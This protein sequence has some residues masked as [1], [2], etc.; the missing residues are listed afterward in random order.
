MRQT[1]ESCFDTKVC[2]ARRR[3]GILARGERIL[4]KSHCLSERKAGLT[5]YDKAQIILSLRQ[6]YSLTLLLKLT[7]L[8]KSTYYRLSKVRQ[9]KYSELKFR[10]VAVFEENKGR[11]GYRR[12]TAQLQNEGWHINHKTVQKLMKCLGIKAKIRKVKYNSYKGEVGKVAENLLNR[13]FHADAPNEKWVTDVTQ[14]TVCGNKV[15]LSPVLDLYNNEI[16][17]YSVSQNPSFWQTREMLEN[18]F[19]QRPTATPILHSDQGWQYQMKPYQQ[20]L[21]S[22]GIRQSMSRKATCLDNAPME[23]FFGRLKQEMFYGKKFN[24][25]EHFIEQLESYLDYYNN[26]RITLKLKG[27][28]PVQYRLQ[29]SHST[30]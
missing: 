19:C 12:I 18:A 14:F 6:K 8:S 28:S 27:L 24:S 3:T 21:R 30:R 13:D 29:S 20:L 25:V 10:I 9:D 22:R 26:R 15:Y 16:V 11:Y 17:A 5:K 4:K 7:G 1:Q 23:S 2:F